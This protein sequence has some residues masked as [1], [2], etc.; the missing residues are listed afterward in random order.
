M[1]RFQKFVLWLS[2]L[3]VALFARQQPAQPGIVGTQAPLQSAPAAPSAPVAPAPAPAVAPA[4]TAAPAPI[5]VPETPLDQLCNFIKGFEG[6]IPP[7]GKDY[8]G[9]KYPL[10]SPSYQCNNPGNLVFAGQAFAT[11]FVI[12]TPNG[13]HTFAKFDTYEHGFEALKR[14][15]QTVANG[16]NQLYKHEAMKRFGLASCA[17]LNL[18]QFFTIYSPSSDGNNPGE[19]GADAAIACGV[20]S[21]TTMQH[22][23]V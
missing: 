6:W 2:N 4:T 14:Q 11:P 18:I 21:S 13:P 16:S 5:P 12:Q 8:A 20:P 17:M 15:I 10:G 22:F 9:K 19:Y 7:G 1:S 23:L 3:Y